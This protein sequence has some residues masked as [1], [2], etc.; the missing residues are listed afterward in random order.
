MEKMATE[1]LN[2][3]TIDFRRLEEGQL[4]RL[5]IGAQ[6]VFFKKTWGKGLTH[7]TKGD[8][9][10]YREAIF[11]ALDPVVGLELRSYKLNEEG[12]ITNQKGRTPWEYLEDNSEEG[13]KYLQMITGDNL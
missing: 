3:K 5:A 6:P 12:Y 2:I 11:I 13:R 10:G 8:R 4:V 7:I 9:Y 1:I